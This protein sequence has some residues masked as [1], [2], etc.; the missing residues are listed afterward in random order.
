MHLYVK[1]F[2]IILDSSI[3]PDEWLKG[4]IIPIY[5]QKGAQGDPRNYRPITILSCMGKLFTS[6]LNN[7]LNVLSNELDIL[8]ENQAGFRKGYST[9]DNIFVLYS[10]ID[11]L[12][13]KKKKLFCTFV[14]FEKAFDKV[15]RSAMWHKLLTYDIQK[16]KWENF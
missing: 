1:I 9:T 5:K 15:W 8:S 7:R 16:C 12:R 14:D 4:N 11:I 3:L 10:L 6:I 2:N 13:S